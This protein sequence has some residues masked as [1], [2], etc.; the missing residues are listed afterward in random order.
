MKHL[1]KAILLAAAAAAASSSVG[2]TRWDLPSGYSPANFHTV[3]LVSFAEGVE[4]ATGGELVIS[5]HPGASLYKAPEIKGAVRSGQVQIGEI[6]MVLLSNEDAVYGID[7]LPFLAT[8]YAD[9]RRLADLQRPY[10]EKLL[11]EQGMA[12]LYSVPWPPQGLHVDRKIEGIG[13]MEGLSFRAYSKQTAR[14]G[15]LAD[16][17]P[18]TIQAAEVSQA[19]ATGK[20]AAFFS[21]AQ[22]GVDYKVWETLE[23]FYDV[24]G[25]LPKNMVIANKA[26]LDALAP[27]VRTAL[28]AEARKAEEAGWRASEQVAEETKARLAAEGIR[29]EPASAELAA[30]FRRIGETMLEEWRA[31]AGPDAQALAEAYAE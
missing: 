17:R 23:Y 29:V 20:I 26:E 25:W 15:E 10:V 18:L 4:Q 14:L 6:L 11:A 30:D 28:L 7:G 24:N 8:S 21:S 2:E 13:D 16:T 3:N 19:L 1:T 27:D 12:Y 5:V 22:S 9:A 31:E